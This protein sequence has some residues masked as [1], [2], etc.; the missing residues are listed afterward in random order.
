[1]DQIY[2][3]MSFVIGALNRTLKGL[4]LGLFQRPWQ[5]NLRLVLMD[6]NARYLSHVHVVSARYPYGRLD[7]SRERRIRK[8]YN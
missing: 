6:D 3:T 1:M 4:N 5:E 7:R 2:L 8:L